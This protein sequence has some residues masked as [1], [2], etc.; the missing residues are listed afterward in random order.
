MVIILVCIFSAVCVSSIMIVVKYCSLL[1]DKMIFYF[2]KM[3][4]KVKHSFDKT[5]QCSF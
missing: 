5:R 2:F 4:H 3:T 1:Q